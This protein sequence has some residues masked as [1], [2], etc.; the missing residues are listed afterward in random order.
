[1]NALLGTVLAGLIVLQAACAL[2]ESKEVIYLKTAQ[3]RATEQEVRQRLGAPKFAATSQAGEPILVYQVM[4]ED[5]GTQ[6]QWGAPG[7]WCD[8]YVLTFDRQGILRRWTKKTEGH[9]G[10]LMPK[11]CVTDGFKPPS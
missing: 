6:N 7:T 11:Y 10:E 2:L 1:M 8:E 3:D 5:P 4:T 9:G